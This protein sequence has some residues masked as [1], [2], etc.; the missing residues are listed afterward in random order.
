[1]YIDLSLHADDY[2]VLVCK[3]KN[4]IIQYLLLVLLKKYV[5]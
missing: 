4:K 1:M 3:N 5:W 2:H